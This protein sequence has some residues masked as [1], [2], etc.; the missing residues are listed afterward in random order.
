MSDSE[1]NDDRSE[2]EEEEDEEEN[3]GSEKEDEDEDGDEDDDDKSGSGSGSGS[4]SDDEE[5]S[6]EEKKKKKEPPAPKLS[7]YQTILNALRDI[8]LDLNS[9]DADVDRVYTKVQTA[10]SIKERSMRKDPEPQPKRNYHQAI[11][12]EEIK[13][14]FSP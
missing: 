9:M 4:G 2:E 8:N 7:K 11:D 10:R 13:R 5:D 12:R 1:D 3:E 14:S 6:D